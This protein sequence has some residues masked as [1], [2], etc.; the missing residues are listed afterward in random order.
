MGESM[1]EVV[2]PLGK[3]VYK[4]IPCAPRISD[5]RGKTICELYD[6][7]FRGD[8]ILPLVRN[9]LQK[10]YEGIKFVNYT[11]FGNIHTHDQPKVLEGLPELLHKH[12]CDAVIG[13][14]GA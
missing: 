11:A 5:L 7:L 10:Q 12:G 9:S 4:K 14:V 3:S 8:E 1:Y 2:W 6:Q 13:L